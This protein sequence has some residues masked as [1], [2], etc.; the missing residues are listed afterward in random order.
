MYVVCVCMCV[1][2]CR[3]YSLSVVTEKM[4]MSI[5]GSIHVPM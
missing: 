3:I 5:E 2:M 1:H 4:D